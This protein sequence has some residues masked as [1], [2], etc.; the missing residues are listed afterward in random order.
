MHEEYFGKEAVVLPGTILPTSSDCNV[1]MRVFQKDCP[2]VKTP[3]DNTTSALCTAE[4]L[5]LTSCLKKI[6][7]S[8]CSECVAGEASIISIDTIDSEMICHLRF[9]PNDH[10]YAL[11]YTIV[12][13]PPPHLAD[14][15]Y[16]R[17][18]PRYAS[19]D[20][21]NV[22]VALHT[23]IAFMNA[24]G[25]AAIQRRMDTILG[26]E[27]RLSHDLGFDADSFLAMRIKGPKQNQP[28]LHRFTTYV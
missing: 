19:Q 16:L 7:S 4:F 17:S 27:I 12:F 11:S 24:K 8:H 21:A 28:C 10:L 26:G 13:Q 15:A 3:P 1:Q 22:G 2:N 5:Q 9:S 18:L 23:S 14:N 6:P 25:V 20:R